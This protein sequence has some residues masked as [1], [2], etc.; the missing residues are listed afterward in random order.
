MTDQATELLENL[1]EGE[2]AAYSGTGS[3]AINLFEGS[4]DL[5]KTAIGILGSEPDWTSLTVSDSTVPSGKYLAIVIQDTSSYGSFTPMLMNSFGK[6]Y[7]KLKEGET[8]TVSVW[9]K[10]VTE[11]SVDIL[12][13][14]ST[15]PT[16]TS[17]GWS[18]IAIT[19]TYT[20]DDLYEGYEP[21]Q[22]IHLN[23]TW[24]NG[25]ILYISSP[26]VEKGSVATD[27]VPAPED[28]PED[29]PIIDNE[30]HI[31]ID[32]K[33]HITV[34]DEL[35]RIAVQYDHNIETVTFDCP[36]YWDGIDLANTDEFVIYINYVLSNGDLGSYIVDKTKVEIDD[37]DSTMMHFPWT[38]SR[39]V[40]KAQGGFKFLVCIKAVETTTMVDEETG[41]TYEGEPIEIHH[42]NSEL[43]ESMYI[44]EGLEGGE[45]LTD[46]DPDFVTYVL[47]AIA[48]SDVGTVMDNLEE[49]QGN[50]NDFDAKLT[51]MMTEFNTLNDT[52][53]T[54][55][56]TF[57]A[58]MSIFEDD[59]TEL[60][61]NFTGKFNE[62]ESQV[63]ETITEGIQTKFSPFETQM[64]LLSNDVA[65][66]Q[67][68]L[69]NF[70]DR[71]DSTDAASFDDLKSRVPTLDNTWNK[72]IL[73][74]DGKKA[75]I[76]YHDAA[77]LYIFIVYSAVCNM[78]VPVLIYLPDNQ[79]PT[80]VI[81]SSTL[82][83]QYHFTGTYAPSWRSAPVI[84]DAGNSG[85]GTTGQ[86]W[87]QCAL[88]PSDST[89]VWVS[90]QSTII[91]TGNSQQTDYYFTN[92]TL[93]NG[94]RILGYQRL[95]IEPHPSIL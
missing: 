28:M 90:I 73:S 61:T 57:D 12:T 54:L 34:P 23:G 82:E 14:C 51:N 32:K 52:F 13:N 68:D 1:T 24:E 94:L 37:T 65:N 75:S 86:F 26:M 77:G 8:Y 70:S 25:D 38:I 88:N 30:P 69:D 20:Y 47:T 10:G 33:R 6:Y 46:L 78:T 22:A 72:N 91:E 36:R 35:K 7:S 92:D 41:E 21:A 66:F 85:A 44:S 16:E 15:L 84:V 95:T 83:K 53:E 76:Y 49:M 71:L 45:V 43:C 48:T 11:I 50:I 58:K 27:W 63:D 5:T 18:R 64:N 2:I 56:N 74:S 29:E 62:L 59:F 87:L 89:N 80:W 3:S 4:G 93:Y 31:I 67:T 19:G 60:E 17:S 39:N 42:W 81:N 40:T 55:N 79:G 9:T